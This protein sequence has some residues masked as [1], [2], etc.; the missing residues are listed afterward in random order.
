MNFVSSMFFSLYDV[1]L[2]LS[3]QTSTLIFTKLITVFSFFQRDTRVSSTTHDVVDR[4]VT[5][6][7]VTTLRDD[8]TSM[9]HSTERLTD[10]R[11]PR[12]QS[13]ESKKP[14]DRS[15]DGKRPKDTSP[16]KK[17]GDDKK[18]PG[19]DKKKPKEES[20][21]KKKPVGHHTTPKEQ[22]VCEICT[23]G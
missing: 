4:A 18:K 14:L 2:T 3:L 7:D 6:S 9:T 23:C 22:C 5:R 21:E 11:G 12:T 10:K 19:D 8:L 13:P 16:D 1:L 15:P 17:P 20:P